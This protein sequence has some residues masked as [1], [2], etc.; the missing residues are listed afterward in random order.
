MYLETIVSEIISYFVLTCVFMVIK[1]DSQES[2]QLLLACENF[3]KDAAR[4]FPDRHG[5]TTV[6]DMNGQRVFITRFIRALRPPQ[7]LLDVFPNSPQ[8]ATVSLFFHS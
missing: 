4:N 2:E 3:E 8:E 1:F 5:L 7:E 6:V